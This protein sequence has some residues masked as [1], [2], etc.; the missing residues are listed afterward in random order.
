MDPNGKQENYKYCILRL[1]LL[2]E[3]R[4]KFEFLRFDSKIMTNDGRCNYGNGTKNCWENANGN[5]ND[6]CDKR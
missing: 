4:R 6:D 1:L 3:W 5:I 2:M